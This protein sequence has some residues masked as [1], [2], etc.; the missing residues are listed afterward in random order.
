MINTA[1]ARELNDPLTV[2]RPYT[3]EIKESVIER[4]PAL[5]KSRYPTIP[6]DDPVPIQY[7]KGYPKW[8]MGP[9]SDKKYGKI[10]SL[11][12]I[13]IHIAKNFSVRDE[14]FAKIPDSGLRLRPG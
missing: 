3:P 7:R 2:H 6:P 12:L 11:G 14:S 8:S 13:G 5:P 10:K 1:R 4:K 9:I